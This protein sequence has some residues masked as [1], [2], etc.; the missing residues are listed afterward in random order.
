MIVFKVS[1]NEN[2][3]TEYSINDNGYNS[4]IKI[5]PE[6]GGILTSF[7]VNGQE[8]FY[9]NRELFLS[10]NDIH[11]GGFPILFPIC[12]S[13]KNDSYYVKNRQYKMPAHGFA[14]D[15]PWKVSKIAEGD[16]GEISLEFADNSF[17]QEVYPYH[18]QC[19]TKYSLNKNKLK[20]CLQITNNGNET[21]PFYL[22]FHPF[23]G[24]E[25]KN[26]LKFHIDADTYLDYNDGLLKTYNG[27][28]DFNKPVD[29]IYYLKPLQEYKYEV[30][31]TCKNKIIV[32]NASKNFKYMVM[33]TQEGQDFLCIEPWMGVPDSLNTGEGVVE[34]HQNE[35]FEAWIE[36]T[37]LPA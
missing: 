17:T 13:L 18:F 3:Y 30:I 36:I 7:Q 25:N 34:L 4:S 32:I 22:G 26:A 2:Q 21:M 15:Y 37:S 12:G 29:F 20:I 9:Y 28:V 23:F 11:A 10:G 33:W 31:D 16:T 19:T 14:K 8:V 35:S 1:I 24:F 27:S 5:V 6:K